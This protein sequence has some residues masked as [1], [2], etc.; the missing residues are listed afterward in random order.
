MRP[1]TV[2][3]PAKVNWYLAVRGKRPDGYH[4]LETLFVRL[5]LCD[6]LTLVDRPSGIRLVTASRLPKGPANLAYRAAALLRDEAGISRG[7]EIRL[8]KRIPAAAGLGGGSSDAAAVLLGLNRLWRLGFSRAKLAALG[9][10]L[11]S[12]VPF[13]VSGAAYALGRGRGERIT[14]IASRRRLWHV[15]VK[16]PFGIATREAY[17]AFSRRAA[18]GDPSLT[19]PGGGVKI[20]IRFLQN[21]RADLLPEGFFN[22]LE[23]V[24][25]NRL[26]KIL[27]I[28]K[29]LLESGAKAALL[30]GSGS[31]VLGVF[32][33]GAQARRAARRL[34]AKRSG[35]IFVVRTL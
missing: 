33:N 30:S 19:P 3:A 25:N 22:N 20:L 24:L 32:E 14:P 12:D 26:K 35:K 16:P 31:T 5:N 7:V 13:F 28:K 17:Q 2:Q 6:T 29:R 18:A 10:R 11:G 1:L 23:V 15:L 21:R 9:A 34:S 4:E 8:R 27:I